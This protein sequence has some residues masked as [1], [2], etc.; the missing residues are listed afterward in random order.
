MNFWIIFKPGLTG[1]KRLIQ[2]LSL[3]LIFILMLSM[4][5]AGSACKKIVDT[6]VTA[7]NSAETINSGSSG[8][9]NSDGSQSSSSTAAETGS[10]SETS[11]Q[12][13]TATEPETTT[14]VIPQE[15]SDLIIKADGYYAGGEYALAS[16]TY[17]DANQAIKNSELSE[18]TQQQQL[19][20]FA[21]KYKKAKDIVDTARMH[22]GN[23]KT[24]EYQ[25]QYEEAKKELEAALAIYPKYKDAIDAYDA[26]KAVMGL[27]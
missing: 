13:S 6:D 7:E 19:A 24:L 25:Q 26:L 1:S 23:A 9:T 5:V 4:I 11:S 18:E 15:I 27:E 3:S 8:T 12:S 20:L 2:I 16:K 10:S 22:Y 14:E 17:R 21:A